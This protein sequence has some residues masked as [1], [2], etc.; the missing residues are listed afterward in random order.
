MPD[1]SSPCSSV[2]L[3]SS[4]CATAFGSE[5]GGIG[6][7]TSSSTAA[8]PVYGLSLNTLLDLSSKG[9]AGVAKISMQTVLTAIQNIY[10]E[11]NSPPSTS[12]STTQ[13]SGGTA[14]A[15]L[16]AQ[17]ANYNLGL[18]ILNANSSNST[19]A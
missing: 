13:Q 10:Q 19:L 14:P 5:G 8:K 16:T 6:G 7:S 17:V 11:T 15:Y 3:I 2:N 9:D 1:M 18:T 4:P 12:S